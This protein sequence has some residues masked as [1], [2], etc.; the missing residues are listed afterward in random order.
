M[1][2]TSAWMKH[3][4]ARPKC[5]LPMHLA[6]RPPMATGGLSSITVK[7][8]RDSTAQILRISR[9]SLTT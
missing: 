1:D 2:E 7:A 6:A 3:R 9:N 4:S 5:N 8:L